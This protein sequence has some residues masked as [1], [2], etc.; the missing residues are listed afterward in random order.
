MSSRIVRKVGMP[1]QLVVC[2]I[3]V[4][5]FSGC[6]N[7]IGDRSLQVKKAVVVETIKENKDMLRQVM[8]SE[9][10]SM[11]GR[12]LAEADEIPAEEI[13]YYLNNPDEMVNDMLKEENGEDYLD[14]IY[15]SIVST[16]HELIMEKAKPL[17]SEE[18]Y[19]SIVDQA[20]QIQSFEE[21]NGATSKGLLPIQS[22]KDLHA[23]GGAAIAALTASVVYLCAWGFFGWVVK[24]VAVLAFSIAIAALFGAIKELKDSMDPAHHEISFLDFWATVGG[25]ALGAGI[26]VLVQT[27]FSTLSVS[28]VL[29]GIAG[30]FIATF[31][32]VEIEIW[33]IFK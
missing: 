14:F 9:L 15:T 26:V 25:G 20:Q 2:L 33:N 8:S 29:A 30:L 5:C 12:T 13:D 22:D 32:F 21:A 3:L 11:T 16:D 1:L 18:D 10:L 19:L 6:E 24:A 17:M 28:P 27:L 7:F 31:G 4:F 23:I